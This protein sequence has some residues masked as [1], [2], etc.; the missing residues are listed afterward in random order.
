MQEV[1]DRP[2][3]ISYKLCG[4]VDAIGEDHALGSK[5]K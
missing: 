3:T 2:Q 1:W 5:Q 4:G